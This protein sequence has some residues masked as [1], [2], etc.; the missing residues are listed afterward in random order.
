MNIKEISEKAKQ[1][2][3]NPRIGFKFWARAANTIHHEVR[4]KPFIAVRPEVEANYN[5]VA[6][7][8]NLLSRRKPSASLHVSPPLLHPRPR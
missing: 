7:G 2:D 4:Y 1:Y 6:T 8:P 3:W 5:L